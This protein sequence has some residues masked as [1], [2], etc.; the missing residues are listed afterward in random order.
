MKKVLFALSFMVMVGL[1]VLAQTTNVTGTVTDASDGSPIPGVSVFVKGTT[2]GTVTTPDGTYTLSVPND[3]TTI[4]FSFV[5]MTT[6]EVAYTGQSKIDARLQSESMDVDEVMVVAYGTAKKESFTGSAEVVDKKKLEKRPVAN[7]TKALEGQVAGVQTTSG[8]CQPGSSASMV[9]RGFGS[10]N[11]GNNPLNVVD[12]I[13]YDGAMNAINPSDIQTVTVLKDAAA[14]ALYGARGANGVVL[15]TTKK[16]NKTGKVEVTLKA[17]NGIANRALEPYDVLNAEEFIET[18]FQGYKN[19]EIYQNGVHP[20]DAGVAAINALANSGTGLFGT[21]EMYNPYDMAVKDLIDPVTGQVNPNANLRYESDWLD[22]ITNDNAL[23]QEY[24]ISLTGGTDKTKLFS[25]FGYLDEEGVLKETNFERYSGRVGAEFEPKKWMKYGGNVAFAQ[26]NT[27]QLGFDGSSTSNV[28]YSAQFMPSIY[29]VYQRDNNGDYILNELG[30]KQ[31]DMGESRPAG[32]SPNFNSVA[33]LYDDKNYYQ[34]DN[35]SGRFHF[36]LLGDGIQQAIRGLKLSVNLGFDK[37]TTRQTVYYNPTHGNAKPPGSGRLSKSSSTGFSYTFNQ[38]LTYQKDFG[39]HSI[40]ILGGHEMYE[41]KYNYLVTSKTGFPFPEIYELSAGATIA[42]S[43]SY[44]HNYHIRSFLSNVS[45]DYKDRYYVSASYRTDGSSR[46][47][48]DAQ[49]GDFWSVGG[50]WR[51]SEEPFM[52][53]DQINNLKLK[54]SYGIQ[55]N[56]RLLNSDGTANFYGWQALYDL[57]WANGS[58]NGAMVNSVENKTLKW[59]ENANFNIGL[60]GEVFNKLGFS[61]EYFNRTTTDMLMKLPMATSL[62]FDSY[63]ANVGEMNN[64]GLEFAL[65]GKLIQTDKVRWNLSVLGSHV[66]NE[67]VKLDGQKDEIVLNSLRI[68]KEGEELNSFYLTRSAGVD[69]ATGDQLYWVWDEDENGVRGEKYISNDKS[70][71][72][73]CREIIGSRIPDLYGSINTDLTVGGFDF[74]LLTTYS[75]GGY[76]YDGL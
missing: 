12:G 14:G 7:V 38:L 62:G 6:K 64:S 52:N 68:N 72:A 25:S 26:T 69:P 70:K 36:D 35:F 55:G 67:I 50:S 32:A 22:E 15:I 1:Q 76:V 43:D 58:R 18:S 2:I 51:I 16:G 57:G 17:T 20:D 23:R 9:I 40:N 71:A 63:W 24:E 33:T 54:A 44:E 30:E 73:S 27:D 46:F 4:A 48:E 41:Y 49:W 65:N 60:E 53:V 42:S 59:E 5:G 13:P 45:Y 47:Y 21:D 29:P 8:G 66:K 74:S 11:S 3:A 34:R 19:Y 75:I 10:I 56:D 61:V 31:F 28:W 39:D 37:Y